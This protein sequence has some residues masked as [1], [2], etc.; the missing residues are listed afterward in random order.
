MEYGSDNITKLH[1]YGNSLS[2]ISTTLTSGSLKANFFI[3]NDMLGSGHFATNTNDGNAVH[4]TLDQWGN[5]IDKI[6]PTFAGQEVNILNTFTNHT[7]DDILGIYHAQARFYDSSQKRFLSPDQN[8]NA[9]NRQNNL[10]SI[11]Q[12]G[13]LYA[14]V[15]NNPLKYTDPTW[16]FLRGLVVLIF[17]GIPG[18]LTVSRMN[19]IERTHHTTF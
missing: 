14:Y 1:T 7:Y 2:R 16:L 13:N 8:W 19:G 12:S 6:M 15:T 11:T 5:V 9:Y 17:P 3:Q 10:A 4:I 18:C